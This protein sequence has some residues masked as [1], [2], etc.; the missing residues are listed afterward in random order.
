MKGRLIIQ[1]MGGLANRMRVIGKLR[2]VANKAHIPMEVL[3]VSNNAAGA[4]WSDIFEL[5]EDFVVKEE[6]GHYKH[7]YYSAKWYRNIVHRVWAWMHRYTWLPYNIV[8]KMDEDTSKEGLQRLFNQ[9]IAQLQA[10]KT[11][12]ISTGDYLGENYDVSFFRPI[13][14]LQKEIDA[15]LP[16][17]K[18]VYGIHIRRTDNTWAIENSPLELFENRITTIL[19]T[20]PNA[21]FYLASDDADT[22]AHFQ[23]RYGACILTRPKTFG[24]NSVQGIQDAI[25]EMWLLSKTKKIYGSFYSSYSGMAAK[26]GNIDLEILKNNDNYCNTI[27]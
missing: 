20:E 4:K 25:I 19:K 11:L 8:E 15:F 27:I 24:R 7:E 26:I 18:K 1:P 21:L 23:E 9:W 10:G 22:I 3:W 2:M 13:V 16:S 14:T 5:P 12:Y 6:S 17:D